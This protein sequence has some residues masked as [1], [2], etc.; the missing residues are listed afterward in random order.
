MRGRYR[1]YQ[2]EKLLQSSDNVIT[3]EGQKEILKFLAGKTN[4]IGDFMA[5]GI[6]EEPATVEDKKLDFEYYRDRVDLREAIQQDSRILLRGIVAE[7]IEFTIHEIGLYLFDDVI[8]ESAASTIITTFNVNDDAEWFVFD[9]S[10]IIEDD[11]SS[12]STRGGRESFALDTPSNET[13]SLIR[14]GFFGNFAD[15]QLDDQFALAYETLSGEADSLEVR[16]RVDENN[17]RSYTF[18][19]S[20]GFNVERWEKADFSEVG[21]APFNEFRSIEIVMTTGQQSCEIVFQGLRVDIIATNDGPLL[22]S[23]TVLD[24]PVEKRSSSELQLEYSIDILFGIN[25][26][27]S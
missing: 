13:Y 24:E 15:I 4:T 27:S 21:Q 17:Y 14:K 6:G 10:E 12:T 2:G 23:R 3:T 8:D 11:I 26:E 18:T 7:N 19:P 20:E 22:V 5:F 1:I 9:G 16:F 25:E